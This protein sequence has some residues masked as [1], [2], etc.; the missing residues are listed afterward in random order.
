MGSDA[1]VPA[2][3][4]PLMESVSATSVAKPEWS[5]AVCL[6]LGRTNRH[7]PRHPGL[8]EYSGSTS[9]MTISPGMR[10]SLQCNER[11]RTLRLFAVL[12]FKKR[13]T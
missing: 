11:I 6:V 5:A 10:L 8:Y 9:K 1:E 2:M 7:R 13:L 4:G 3:N 12:F